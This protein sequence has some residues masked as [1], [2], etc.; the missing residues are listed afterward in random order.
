MIAYITSTYLTNDVL[1]PTCVI[2]YILASTN[3]T[4]ILIPSFTVHH[5]VYGYSHDTRGSHAGVRYIGLQS[6]DSLD[7]LESLSF[8]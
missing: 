3:I 7:S 6:W 2:K 8:L 5:D 4:N 1:L